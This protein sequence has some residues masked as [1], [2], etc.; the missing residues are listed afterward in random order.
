M[1][2]KEKKRMAEPDTE[3]DTEELV[4]AL[5]WISE[6]WA[7]TACDICSQPSKML[8]TKSMPLSSTI[9]WYSVPSGRVWKYLARNGRRQS[10]QVDLAP[11][12]ECIPSSQSKMPVM[13]KASKGNFATHVF[14]R[15]AQWECK[16]MSLHKWSQTAGIHF[17][18][19]CQF[20]NC[21]H[22]FHLYYGQYWIQ[23]RKV[24]VID[25]PGAFLYSESNE[26]VIMMMSGRLAELMV[27]TALQVFI[28]TS[29]WTRKETWCC[30][31]NYN[32]HVIDVK[33]C[34][35]LFQQAPVLSRKC[36]LE[37]QSLQPIQC[38]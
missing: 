8:M 32:R 7:W 31:S 18:K 17:E 23:W 30:M 15:K 12:A 22:E 28:I 19:E 25:L 34:T 10:K 21:E 26:E 9:W 33:E 16:R 24:T 4:E 11:Y 37:T 6:R 3:M 35:S 27:P 29:Q 38:S 5:W 13:W 2:I 14:E 20:T 1:F 36:W